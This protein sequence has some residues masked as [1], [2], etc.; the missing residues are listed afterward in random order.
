MKNKFKLYLYVVSIIMGWLSLTNFIM[1]LK[2][3]ILPFK[4]LVILFVPLL[5]LPL[6][7]VI[8]MLKKRGKHAVKVVLSVVSI[9]V[10]IILC[11]LLFYL[12]R[13]F[14]FLDSLTN[15]DYKVE[16][17]LVM[18]L[19]DSDYREI[20]D[21]NNKSLGY[22]ENGM[23]QINNALLKLDDVICTEKVL[24]ESYDSLVDKL[25][26]NDVAAIVVLESYNN[27]LSENVKDY[28]VKTRVLYKISV[29]SLEADVVK[30]VDV[31]S[32][33]FNVYIS[34]ID[35]FGDISSVS[36][37]DVNII[38]SI[39]PSTHQ[40]LLTTIPR[41]YYVLLDGTDGYKDKLTHAGI[42]GIDKSIK[43]IENL[44]DIEI[45]YYFKV[46][47][48]SVERIVD[49]LGGVD[50]YSE[51]TFVGHEG[52]LFSKGYNRVNGKLALEFA[53]TRYTVEGGDRSRGKNQQALISALI[54]KACSKNI[55]TKYTS[56]LDS[57]TGTFATNMSTEKIS[58]FVK[59]QLDDM[60]TW[61]VTSISLDGSNG[62][63]YTYSYSYQQ[64]YV[65][66]PDEDT[67]KNAKI[68]IE[69]I[70]NNEVLEG[71]Y[72]ENN[73]YVNI[74]TVIVQ[75]NVIAEPIPNDDATPNINVDENI[76]SNEEPD[77]EIEEQIIE[78]DEDLNEV[79]DDK[80]DDDV[81]VDL[82]TDEEINNGDGNSGVQNET[83]PQE[84]DTDIDENEDTE[85]LDDP[86]DILEEKD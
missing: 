36:R 3:D 76:I 68:N 52:A 59:K 72:I 13:T 73:G 61:N 28:K 41:D 82:S 12:N 26:N 70:F 46:N 38:A 34:G 78:K 86:I 29:S 43:T 54:N 85:I 65:M 77:E 9:I 37:S 69:K 11:V 10:S 32:D 24:D 63:E 5:L 83:N 74:P 22:V 50:V 49:S 48:S 19:D 75:N 27:I 16:N 21:L 1:I 42:Y 79:S 71:S 7:L 47:F 31:E 39:N 18:V 6:I 56:L 44:L 4:Y 33:S 62:Y 15:N 53:R 67:I 8:S 58:D 81:S 17:Y 20:N 55:I 66:I 40:I 30:N 14:N 35:T 45:N 25:Y 51:Y 2:Y 64:L 80:I 57:L 84:T 60:S 23:S